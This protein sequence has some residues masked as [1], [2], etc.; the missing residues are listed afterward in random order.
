MRL[1]RWLGARTANTPVVKDIC[2]ALSTLKYIKAN[3]RT[4]SYRYIWSR[5]FVAVR[6]SCFLSISS[7]IYFLSLSCLWTK[8]VSRRSDFALSTLS[9]RKYP[10]IPNIHIYIRRYFSRWFARSLFFTCQISFFSEAIAHCSANRIIGCNHAF[11]Y[12]P[13]SPI[14]DSLRLPSLCSFHGAPARPSLATPFHAP[15]IRTNN[16]TKSRISP[17][18]EFRSTHSLFV[19]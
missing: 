14:V 13:P 6:L 7:R 11:L 4:R 15:L 19:D 10:H 18:C 2:R 16:S 3:W 8:I 9:F 12:R 17:G 5:L 1:R